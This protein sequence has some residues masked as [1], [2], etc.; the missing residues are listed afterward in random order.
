MQYSAIQYDTIQYNTIQHSTVQYIS[1]SPYKQ[2]YGVC[3]YT[4][5]YIH[6]L[7]I[8]YIH[9]VF[10]IIAKEK[11]GYTKIFKNSLHENLDH[12]NRSGQ[13]RKRSPGRLKI[14]QKTTKV[15][16][17]SLGDGGGRSLEFP[18]ELRIWCWNVLERMMRDSSSWCHY[19]RDL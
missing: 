16:R 6:I 2:V 3:K 1:T 10:N 13:R 5:I 17:R 7:Y 12:G 15:S 9:R 19:F 18:S 8:Y 11:V 4:Y 14:G